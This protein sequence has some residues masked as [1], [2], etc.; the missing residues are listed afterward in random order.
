MTG[1]LLGA[2]GAI[3]ALVCVKVLQNSILPPTINYETP[4]PDCDLDYVPNQ[5]RPAVVEKVMSNSFGFGG[6]NATIILGKYEP[7]AEGATAIT[8]G[9]TMSPYAHITGWGMAVPQRIVTNAELALRIDTNDEWIQSRTGIRERRIA[10]EDQTTASLGVDA[11]TAA[12]DMARL[13]PADLDLIIVSTSSPE[14]IFPATAC[15]VQDRLGAE[16]SRSLRP[17]G[18]LFRFYFCPEYGHASHPH[19]VDQERF[20]H[21]LGNAVAHR[22]LERPQHL[23][24]V[25]R[26]RRGF[27]LQASPEPGGV[28]SAVM[29]SDGSGGDLLIV[30]GGGSRI[31]TTHKSVQARPALHPDERARGFPLCHA[32]PGSGHPRSGQ[33]SPAQHG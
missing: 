28:I 18:G 3:E 16:Q 24:L 4:D 14:H 26:W 31:P 1:H 15:L 22:G 21:R 2:S 25:R 23:H 6:H 29:R 11:A 8:G 12:L 30:P 17:A 32:G 10:S 13:K 7:Q 9:T 5:A 27:V 19:R 33:E 20:G